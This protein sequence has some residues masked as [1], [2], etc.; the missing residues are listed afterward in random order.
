M[1]ARAAST[2]SPIATPCNLEVRGISDGPSAS[3]AA[4]V[5]NG[6]AGDATTGFSHPANR[7]DPSDQLTP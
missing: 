6:A 4:T 3:I 1:V 5:S 7:R 2:L